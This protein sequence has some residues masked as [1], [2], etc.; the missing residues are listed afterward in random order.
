LF[1]LFNSRPMNITYPLENPHSKS[2]EEIVQAL[3]TSADEGISQSEAKSRSKEFGLNAV[4]SQKLKSVRLMVLEQFQSPI[5][6]LLVAGA[7]VSLYFKDVIEAIAIAAVILVNALIGFLM[8]LQARNSMNALRKMDII[9]CKVLRPGGTIHEIP[10]ENLAPGDVVVLEAGDVIPGDGRLVEMNQLQCDESSLT[11][12]S[13]PSEKN[14][15]AL[16][17]DTALGDK[18]N[19]VFKGSAVI[20]GNGK[21][22]ITGIAEHTELGTITSLVENSEETDTPLDKK[23]SALAQK[24]IWLTLGL[25]AIFAVTGIIEGKA[26]VL[27]I[28]TS[29]ALAIAAFP[30]GL[31]IVATVSLSYGMLLMARRNAIV[32][33]LSSVETLGSTT[34]ILTDKTGTLTENKIYVDTFSFPKENVKARIENNTLQFEKGKIEKSAENFEMVK[35]IGALC[36][37]ASE[38]TAEKA[39]KKTDEKKTANGTQKNTEDQQKMLGDPI[40]IALLQLANSSGCAS[41]ASLKGQYERIAEMPFNSDTKIMGTLHKSSKGYLIAAKGAVEHLLEKCNTMQSGATLEEFGEN[42]KKVVLAESETMSAGGLRVL[43]FAYKEQDNGE[44]NKSDFLKDLVYVGMIGFLDPPRLDIKEAIASCRKA[45]IKVVMITGDHPMTALNIAKKTGLVDEG[46]QNVIIGKN[47]PSMDALTDEWKKKILSTAVF[48]RATPKQKLDIAGI[49]QKAG[50]IVA[51]TGDGVNDA[52]ALKKANVGI[53][54]GLRGTQVAKEAAS[55]VL[56][57]DSFT[58]IAAAIANGRTILQN[59][60]KFVIYLVSCNLSEIFIVTGLGFLSPASTLL[61]MQILFLNMVTD[62]FPALALGLGKGETTVM[63]KPPKDPKQSI[64]S[65]KE[66]REI[67]VYAAAMTL[68]V[69]GAVMYCEQTITTDSNVLNNV[70]FITL[71]CVQLFHVFNMASAKS[72][73]FVNDITKNKFVWLALLICTGL[74][75]LVYVVP[76]TRLVLSLADLSPEIWMVS[77]VASALPLVALQLYKRIWEGRTIAVN[78]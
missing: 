1:L 5:V 7:A 22:V 29:I 60:Q 23:L 28:K 49:Y 15:D 44:P 40:E 38:E 10:S 31:P 54:M 8:E 53:A 61:P 25:T 77:V 62:V 2:A 66:W 74:L 24:L 63:D 70:A 43:A 16:P 35:L 4:P 76:Q 59:I 33:K 12:E 56:K 50:N 48:A 37:N 26:W 39:D 78:V 30:E 69:V 27:I 3:Q 47:L 19:M 42:E 46:E 45:G 72:A 51:M 57:D 21:A 13:L 6:Y 55:I 11:G 41:A 75:V 34:V 67:A 58:S 18:K 9:K 68:A 64:V 17:E 32:K 14:S 52:P 36:N 20:N 71:V 73:L 65:R